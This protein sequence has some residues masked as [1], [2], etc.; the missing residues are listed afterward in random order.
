M[1]FTREYIAQQT[2]AQAAAALV[3]HRTSHQQLTTLAGTI[4]RRSYDSKKCMDGSETGISPS[5]LQRRHNTVRR[6]GPAQGNGTWG[7]ARF[8]SAWLAHMQVNHAA[9]IVPCENE[10]AH[11]M[12]RH[13]RWLASRRWVVLR[14]EQ[15]KLL[16][17]HDAWRMHETHDH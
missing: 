4:Q 8:A 1:A 13:A 16:R 14:A 12:N 7:G 11:G 3:A 9:A 17:W 15:T 10:L 6:D 2:Q 5:P